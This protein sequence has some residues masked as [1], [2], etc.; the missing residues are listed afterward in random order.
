MSG[1]IEPFTTVADLERRWHVLTAAERERA[2]ALLEDST[3]L[4]MDECPRWESASE[5]TWRAVCCNA[6]MRR[7]AVADGQLGV[8][9]AQQTAGSFSESFTYA[10]PMSDLYLTR[11]EKRRLGSGRPHAFSITLGGDL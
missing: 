6:V 11:A 2:T 3:Q 4:I 8:S 5:H 7:M 9:N 1:Q 10:N